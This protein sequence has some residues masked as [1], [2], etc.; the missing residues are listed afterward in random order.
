MTH[1]EIFEQVRGHVAGA[2]GVEPEEVTEGASFA[3]DL[4]AE[5]LDM[6]DMLFRIEKSLGVKITMAEIGARIRGG[7]TVEEFAQDGKVT[8][9][10]LAQLKRA[11]PQVNL[12]AL[13][14]DLAADSI[15]TFFTVRNLVDLVEERVAAAVAGR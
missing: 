6:L 14:G 2:L 7:L 1:E 3:G 12:D 9:A 5:S 4:G 13:N 8:P 15:F 10:G 11:L